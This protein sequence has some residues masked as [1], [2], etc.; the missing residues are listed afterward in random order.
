MSVRRARPP[1]LSGWGARW[2]RL[3]GAPPSGSLRAAKTARV[4]DL[5]IGTRGASARVRDAHGRSS[6]PVIALDP[7][8]KDARE[9]AIEALAKK[10]SFAASL[11]AGRLPDEVDE[12]LAAAGS[13]TLLPASAGEIH[14]SCTC[15][16]PVPCRHLLALHEVLEERLTRDP[17]L[18]F[19][20]RGIDEKSLLA[21][22]RRRRGTAA[23]S[24]RNGREP[25]SGRPPSPAA[26]LSPLPDVPPE[27]FFRPLAPASSFAA[28]YAPATPGDAVLAGLGPAP[29]EDADAARLLSELH[30]AIGLGAKERLS[31]WEWRRS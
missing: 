11:L 2:A 5:E 10:A 6:E 12:I 26:R 7:F 18:L 15:G 28:P 31:E 19:T 13:R 21:G 23:S 22:L 1:A 27:R 8:P 9:R 24:E 14:Q 3:A 4:R 25:A 20:L 16:E 30:R 17:F 29:F